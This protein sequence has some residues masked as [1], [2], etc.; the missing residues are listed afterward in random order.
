MQSVTLER[1][2]RILFGVALI[3]SLAMVLAYVNVPLHEDQA[4]RQTQTAL[5]VYWL[6][7]THQWLR[8]QTPVLGYPWTVPFEFPTFQ[9]LVAL[10]HAVLPWRLDTVGRLVSIAFFYATLWP[11]WLLLK[12]LGHS[13]RAFFL[14]GILFLASPMMITWAHTFMI[15]SCALFLAMCYLA[16]VVGFLK[17]RPQ[18]WLLV[19]TSALGCFAILT[20]ATTF[21]P[22]AYVAFGWVV[23]HAYSEGRAALTLRKLLWFYLPIGVLW[24]VLPILVQ[25][26]WDTLCNALKSGNELG[27]VITSTRLTGWNFGTLSQRFS[28]SLWFL[29][30][31]KKGCGIVA[32]YPILLIVLFR[33]FRTERV[34]TLM[35]MFWFV[36]Y[37]L[38]PLTFSNL[39]WQGEYWP[40]VAIYL[41]IGSGLVLELVWARGYVKQAAILLTAGLLLQVLALNPIRFL[42]DH[43]Q[44]WTDPSYQIGQFIKNH[45]PPGSF[46]LVYGND[47]SSSVAYYAE[48]KSLTDP[49][50]GD[51]QARLRHLSFYQGGLPLSA[52]VLCPPTSPELL[53]LIQPVIK[54]FQQA[55]VA[56]CVIH[57]SGDKV[58]GVA[59]EHRSVR[60]NA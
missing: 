23:I 45:T 18:V 19:L 53:A 1:W 6:P 50:W 22:A 30:L 34:M 12:A 25:V 54:G 13:R 3:Y 28:G 49:Q 47:W 59:D 21:V 56:G 16:G 46:I 4:F 17:Q 55:R 20:K 8:Y 60:A 9:W 58:H 15:E 51:W 11:L 31:L 10:V 42:T 29:I 5:T 57:W 2:L 38:G 39:Y 43:A 36:A 40:E 35:T 24:F 14:V 27:V 41:I 44:S 33:F 26:Q 32:L 48:R 52:V 7:F 37:L